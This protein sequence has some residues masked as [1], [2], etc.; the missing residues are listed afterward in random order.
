MTTISPSMSVPREDERV[1]IKTMPFFSQLTMMT[2]R[3]LYTLLRTPEAVIPSLLISAFFLIIYDASL[4]DAAGFL[5]GLSGTD[6]LA[7]VLPLSVISASLNSPAGQ[8]IVRDIESGYFDKLL[9]TPI[10]RTALLLAPIIAASALVGVQTIIITVIALL[11]GLESATGVPGLLA[12]MGFALLVGTGFSGFTIGIALRTNNAAATQGASFIFF[13]LSFLTA[14][15]VPVE[16]LGGWLEV[17]ARLNP[18]TYILDAT[19]TILISGWDAE[20]ILIGLLACAVLGILPFMFALLS[21]RNRTAR[22]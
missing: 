21:L 4:G 15:F 11:M 1:E 16:L 12:V 7:F 6:Y 18:I 19:R 17:A 2:W 22:K 10:S 20:K 14:T 3:S 13:P 9:L 5:P 8:A